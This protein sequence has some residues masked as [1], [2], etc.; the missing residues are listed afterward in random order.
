VRG[1]R[2]PGVARRRD[3]GRARPGQS[4]GRVSGSAGLA[5]RSGRLTGRVHGAGCRSGSVAARS[6]GAS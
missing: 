2:H 4:T 5:R 3:S 1:A 6:L